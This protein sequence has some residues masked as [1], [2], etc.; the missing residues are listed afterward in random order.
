MNENEKTIT[1][2][3]T[4]KI[5]KPRQKN[6]VQLKNNY[7]KKHL[8]KSTENKDI[9]HEIIK[10]E[11]QKYVVC[12]VISKDNAINFFVVDHNDFNKIR[13]F[14]WYCGKNGYIT[15]SFSIGNRTIIIFVCLFIVQKH[16]IFNHINIK[17]I[18]LISF[19]YKNAH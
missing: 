14:K 7:L 12:K 19:L 6:S 13:K 10:Y 16:L 3:K 17:I 1:E 5:N 8:A 15:T 18:Y 4:T 11:N 2:N 9:I